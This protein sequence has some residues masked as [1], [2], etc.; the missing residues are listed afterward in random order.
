[1][2]NPLLKRWKSMTFDFSSVIEGE[3]PWCFLECNLKQ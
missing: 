3:G 2:F 1:M